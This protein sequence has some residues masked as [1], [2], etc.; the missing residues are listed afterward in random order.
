MRVFIT[1]D[2]G[3]KFIYIG[4]QILPGSPNIHVYNLNL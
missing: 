4:V 3:K 2:T 1:V